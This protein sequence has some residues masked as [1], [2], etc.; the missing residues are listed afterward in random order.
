MTQLLRELRRRKRDEQLQ[1]TPVSPNGKPREGSSAYRDKMRDHMVNNVRPALEAAQL[2]DALRE[3]ETADKTV[4]FL[5]GE[6]IASDDSAV[7]TALGPLH[8]ACAYDEDAADD[9]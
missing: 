9:D 6:R 7:E 3:Y 4:C 1:A 5:C 2:K 8:I